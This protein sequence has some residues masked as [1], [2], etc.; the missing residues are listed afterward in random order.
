MEL[1]DLVDLPDA[2][3]LIGLIGI[4][5]F[6][7]AMMWITAFSVTYL[8]LLIFRQFSKWIHVKNQKDL[9]IFST[10][11]WDNVI[12]AF[13]YASA[14]FMILPGI[15]FAWRC[16][17]NLAFQFP[18]PYPGTVISAQP[19]K[20]LA[21][22]LGMREKNISSIIHTY[23]IQIPISEVE[24]YYENKMDESCSE[25]RT[26]TQFEYCNG[27]IE[28]L[29]AECDISHPLLILI[30]DAM[31]FEVTLRSISQTETKVVY[32][33]TTRDPMGGWFP[34]IFGGLGKKNLI[35]E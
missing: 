9:L 6:P 33:I 30:R 5:L 3:M 27:Y 17:E 2:I 11:T 25:D 19:M 18:N 22:V 8:L 24:E 35:P 26:F 23:S 16:Y 31:H 21:G 32:T 29:R 12:V 14:M 34:N 4:V 20:D 13:I 15:V 10:K 28:C 7:I 1:L